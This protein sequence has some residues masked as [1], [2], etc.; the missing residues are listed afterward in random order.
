MAMLARNVSL[1][2]GARKT[3]LELQ[4]K[5]AQRKMYLF[6]SAVDHNKYLLADV[7]GEDSIFNAG[8]DYE[9][10]KF[11]HFKDI[12]K[13]DYFELRYLTLDNDEQKVFNSVMEGWHSEHTQP[14]GLAESVVL[15]SKYKSYEYLLVNIWQHEHDYMAWCNSQKNE[16]INFGHG[17][18]QKPIVAE[19]VLAK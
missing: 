8:L 3:L 15:R 4:N 10:V 7:S 18:N 1:T 16:L 14:L 11:S 17:G 12:Q 6:K 2:L 5:Y 19:Y 9:V 13:E